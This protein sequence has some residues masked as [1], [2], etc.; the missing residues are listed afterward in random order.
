MMSSAIHAKSEAEMSRK[1]L[2]SFHAYSLI[3][4]AV[5]NSNGQNIQLVKLRNPWGKG[6]WTG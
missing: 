6:E 4:A 3:Q 1:G 5:V 2:H